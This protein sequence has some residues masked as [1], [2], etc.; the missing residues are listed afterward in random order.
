MKDIK[1]IKDSIATLENLVKNRKNVLSI[2]EKEHAILVVY[3][4]LSYFL[5]DIVR[6]NKDI[7]LNKE[8]QTMLNQLNEDIKSIEQPTK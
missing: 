3:K 5:Y 1:K 8:Q 2:I 6:N 7:K 4:E